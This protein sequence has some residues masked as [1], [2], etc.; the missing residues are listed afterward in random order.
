MTSK[1]KLSALIGASVAA[2]MA[3]TGTA[4]ADT[5]AFGYSD[6]GSGYQL[7]MLDADPQQGGDKAKEGSCGEKG[8]DGKCGEGKCGEKAAA[9]DK[10][11]DGKCGEGKCGEKAAAGDKSKD[12]KCGEG[13]CGEG[14]CGEK[15]GDAAEPQKD[16]K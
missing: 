10:S 1:T 11:K 14:K 8:K 15:K 5:N 4:S 7:A 13:K 12:G 16:K 2:S 3:M 6:L 9:G